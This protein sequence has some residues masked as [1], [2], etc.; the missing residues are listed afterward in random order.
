MIIAI[1]L[2]YKGISY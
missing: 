1:N 2:E